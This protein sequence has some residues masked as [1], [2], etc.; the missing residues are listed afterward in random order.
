VNP[1][2]VALVEPLARAVPAPL[3]AVLVGGAT[4]L[5]IALFLSCLHLHD[6]GGPPTGQSL[7]TAVSS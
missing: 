5:S 2:L 7:R 6:L 1:G 4:N 3:G